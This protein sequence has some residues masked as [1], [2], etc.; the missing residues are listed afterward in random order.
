VRYSTPQK[1]IHH[2]NWA[3]HIIGSLA[4]FG[5]VLFFGMRNSHH[6]VSVKLTRSAIKLSNGALEQLVYTIKLS[7]TLSFFLSSLLLTHFIHL[8]G[9]SNSD[10]F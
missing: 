1:I 2:L 8:G 4:E 3:R 7:L 9:G 10:G 5:G 6:M